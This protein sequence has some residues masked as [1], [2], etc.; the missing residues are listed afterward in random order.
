M[1]YI[2]PLDHS[3]YSQKNLESDDGK[4]EDIFDE[5]FNKMLYEYTE[6]KISNE[7]LIKC[8][9]IDPEKNSEYI[10]PQIMLCSQ[11]ILLRIELDKK[12]DQVINSYETFIN[13]M[14]WLCCYTILGISNLPLSIITI[15]G[16]INCFEF[17]GQNIGYDE[18]NNF[19]SKHRLQTIDRY[20]YFVFLIGVYYGVHICLWFHGCVIDHIFIIGCIPQIMIKI[21]KL[22]SYFRI[23]NIIYNAYNQMIKKIVCKQFTKIINAVIKNVLHSDHRLEYTDFLGC[24]NHINLVYIGDF[25]AQFIGACIF[26]YLDKG[27]LRLPFILYKNIFMKDKK[28][29][30][31]NDHKYFEKIV[32]DKNWEK[33]M[34][35]YT[36]N[37]LIR[38]LSNGN[39]NNNFMEKEVNK[40]VIRTI[41]IF[42]MI[43]FGWTVMNIVHSV[44]VGILC[45]LLF[46]NKSIKKERYI[47]FTILCSMLSRF[48]NEN[49]LSIILC[50][51]MYP[52]IESQLF[53]DLMYDVLRFL[54]QSIYKTQRDTMLYFSH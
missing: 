37:R 24:Y 47:L 52:V 5:K 35:I 44:T 17:Y 53:P 51:I 10:E 3:I 40:L 11:Y 28:Y 15:D 31:V 14:I 46:V 8:S 48:S 6:Q 27:R 54:Y 32:I 7:R 4:D 9:V 34:D 18:S 29:H 30:I 23:R 12:Y 26:N 39:P 25:I 13:M 43:I 20:I 41:F 33:F 21:Y 2:H 49:L 1:N 19:F 36:L 22:P 38:M 45:N 16:I 42:N 50:N